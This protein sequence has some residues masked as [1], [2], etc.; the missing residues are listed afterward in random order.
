MPK[1]AW[2]IPKNDTDRLLTSVVL[3]RMPQTEL[4]IEDSLEIL[5]HAAHNHHDKVPRK[6]QFSLFVAITE[7]C[8][9]YQCTSPLELYVEHMWLPYWREHATDAMLADVLLISYVFGLSN[10][11]TRLSRLAILNMGNSDDVPCKSWPHR[12]EEMITTVC[13]S[14]VT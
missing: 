7:V 14:K 13:R 10:N 9:R 5:L 6:V 1:H 11:F 2:A 4:N 3:Y 8:L 12:V